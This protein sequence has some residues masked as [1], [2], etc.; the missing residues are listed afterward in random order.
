MNVLIIGLGNIGKHYYK[1]C[2]KKGYNVFINDPIKQFRK[3]YKYIDLKDIKKF[4]IDIGIVCTP[5]EDHFKSAYFLLSNN[6]NTLVEK[7]LVLKI[8]DAKRLIS[9]SKKRKVKC[10]VVFQNRY[11]ATTKFLK[12]K[13]KHDKNIFML[14]ANLFWHR[15]KK[16][17]QEGWRGKYKTDGGVLTNQAIHLLD[18]LIYNFGQIYEFNS[19]FGFNRK[20]LEAEDLIL[21]QFLFKK[22]IFCNFTATTRASKDYEVSLDILSKKNRYKISGKSLNHFYIWK[23]NRFIK[24]RKFSEEFPNYNDIRNGIGNGHE[25]ILDEFIISKKSSEKLE[26]EQNLYILKLIHSIY[27]SIGTRK[28]YVSEKESI[29]GK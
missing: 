5:S 28:C 12:K 26:I 23:K 15:N 3:N 9:L 7:P 21:V 17:Y 29:L 19:M 16:Y 18:I 14:N 11:N 24:L 1:L 2:K 6:I 27:N 20:K 25:R 4:K 10:W 13:L 22:K 8:S